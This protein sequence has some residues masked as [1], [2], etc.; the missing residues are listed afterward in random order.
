MTNRR[1]RR[2]KKGV[3]SQGLL[4]FLL[5]T[6]LSQLHFILFR[7]LDNKRNG[8][9]KCCFMAYGYFWVFILDLLYV[10]KW[11]YHNIL[12]SILRNIL[13][14]LNHHYLQP[15]FGFVVYILFIFLMFLLY[16]FPDWPSNSLTENGKM[17]LFPLLLLILILCVLKFKF[18]GDSGL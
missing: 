10:C 13:D 8:L 5:L 1:K 11:R 9:L 14:W 15:T 7:N 6:G 16:F 18:E 17:W 12:Q 3:T 4:Y 2:R